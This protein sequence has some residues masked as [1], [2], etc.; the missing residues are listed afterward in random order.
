MTLPTPLFS[1]LPL[2][3]EVM[4]VVFL[5]FFF[6]FL[7]HFR[8]FLLT[9]PFF[10]GRQFLPIQVSGEGGVPADSF[11]K[12]RSPPFDFVTTF[13][14]YSRMEMPILYAPLTSYLPG[15]PDHLFFSSL[16]EFLEVQGYSGVSFLS[17]SFF[18]L[19]LVP[20]FSRSNKIQRPPGGRGV[21]LG[22]G[23]VDL[24]P[25]RLFHPPT[26][27]KPLRPA[28]VTRAVSMTQ[29]MNYSLSFSVLPALLTSLGGCFYINEGS[30]FLL[31]SSLH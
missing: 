21:P 24:P 9:H 22:F 14:K 29:A 18:H 11:G 15:P 8:A 28:C 30:F 7:I 10:F 19:L 3:M 2:L 16:R 25:P 26:F 27:L 13:P 6:F 20:F 4:R 17:S 5:V 1:S 31:P 12:R 23:P